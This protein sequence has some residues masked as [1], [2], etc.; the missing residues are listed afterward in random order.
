VNG[1]RMYA[2]RF[3]VLV[4]AGAGGELVFGLPVFGVVHGV[5][6]DEFASGLGGDDVAE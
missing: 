3:A 4:V 1:Q 2:Y 5:I 6:G